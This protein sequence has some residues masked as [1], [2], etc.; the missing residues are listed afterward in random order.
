MD[1]ERA[2]VLSAECRFISVGLQTLLFCLFLT[3]KADPIANEDWPNI[4]LY[5]TSDGARN[6]YFTGFRIYKEE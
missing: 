1:R 6:M 5:A 2:A 3:K 4:L